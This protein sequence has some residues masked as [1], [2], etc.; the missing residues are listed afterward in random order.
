MRILEKTCMLPLA[1]TMKRQIDTLRETFSADLDKP[2][3][4]K[5]EYVASLQHARNETKQLTLMRQQQ[6][7]SSTS[8]ITSNVKV[9]QGY[10][11]LGRNDSTIQI[12]TPPMT[13]PLPSSNTPSLQSH[14]STLTPPTE[15]VHNYDNL[16]SHAFN[17]WK[18]SSIMQ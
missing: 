1:R 10:T 8:P 16:M 11:P 13:N 9:L 6:H 12:S 18:P 15:Q 5:P 2:F 17:T 4:L 14:D 3:E 7:R